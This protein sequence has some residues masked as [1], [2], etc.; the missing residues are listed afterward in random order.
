M[1]SDGAAITL[2]ISGPNTPADIWPHQDYHTSK[3]LTAIPVTLC[4]GIYED[5][6]LS[7]SGSVLISTG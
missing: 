6:I 7:T 1:Q 3:V 4:C 5:D 2:S